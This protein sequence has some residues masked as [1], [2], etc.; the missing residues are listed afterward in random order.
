M[1]YKFIVLSN[2]DEAFMREFEFLDT[3]T[4]LDFHYALQD[5]LEFDKSQMASFYTATDNWEKEEEFTLLDMGTGSPTMESAVLE[6]VIFRKNQK[7]L[8]IFDFFNERGLFV[9]YIGEMKEVA[10]KDLPICT[11]AKGAAPKQVVFGGKASSKLYSNIVISDDEFEE[12]LDELYLD[13]EDEDVLS[14]YSNIEG[15]DEEEE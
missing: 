10:G 5:E 1:I 8:Y 15:V 11:N 3:H 7:L 14:E 6:D 4:L 9:E 2:E 13:E 12:D